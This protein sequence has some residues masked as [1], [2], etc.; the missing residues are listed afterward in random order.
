MRFARWLLKWNVPGIWAIFDA[1]IKIDVDDVDDLFIIP[2]SPI[3]STSTG[4][5]PHCH[6]HF[7]R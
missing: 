2:R 1:L 5:W 7:H 6:R 4:S 3:V